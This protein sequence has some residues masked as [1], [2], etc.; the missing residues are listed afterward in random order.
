MDRKELS[1]EMEKIIKDVFNATENMLELSKEA[2][3]S[4][5]DEASILLRRIFYDL[6]ENVLR[7]DNPEILD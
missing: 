4:G 6:R 5:F 3:T 1:T 2:K 7:L